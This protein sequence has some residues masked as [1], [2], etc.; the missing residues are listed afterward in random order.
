MKTS[1]R[2]TKQHIIYGLILV[3]VVS[4]LVYLG[5]YQINILQQDYTFQ[6]TSLKQELDNKQQQINILDNN[7][8]NLDADLKTLDQNVDD[9]SKEYNL[10]IK[11]L[12][13]TSEQFESKIQQ[14]EHTTG[15]YEVQIGK[16]DQQLSDLVVE[17]ESFIGVISDVIDSVVS[18]VTNTGQGSGAIISS[19]GLIVT[20]YHVIRG[21]RR[22]SVMTYDGNNYRIGLVGYDVKNDL[23][24]LKINSNET[25]QYFKFGNSDTLKAGQKVVALGNPAG[26]SFTATEGIISS[27]SRL[28]NDGLYYIQ[29]DVTLNPGNSGGPLINSKGELIGIVDFKVSGYEGLGFAIPSNRVEE[30][31]DEILD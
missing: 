10:Q 29:T 19:E 11:R 25:F 8:K 31:I 4:S 12:S 22:A 2:N 1:A 15:L 17:S 5:S 18:I 21:A 23:A 14:L 13:E 28:A 7:I 16:L 27:P 6:I 20:N 3:I 30:V 24:V 26:L 9:I